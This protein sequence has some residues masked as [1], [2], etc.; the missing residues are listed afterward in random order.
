MKEEPDLKFRLIQIL[1]LDDTKMEVVDNI[2]KVAL[3][4][5]WRDIS[6]S[7][8]GRGIW[9]GPRRLDESGSPQ[10]A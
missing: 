7:V 10:A 1:K 9:A 5:R 6:L 2:K 3:G 8:E 4:G